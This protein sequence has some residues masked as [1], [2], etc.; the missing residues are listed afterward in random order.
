MGDLR[1][2]VR[3]EQGA[4]ETLMGA[5]PGF[6]GYQDKEDRRDAD[7]LLRM[8]LVGLLND[9]RD[10]LSRFQA[11]LTAEGQ[12]KP[13]T[14]LNR[15]NRRLLRTRD[16]IEHASYGYAGFFDPI[17]VEAA[18][19]D[20]LY[21]FDRSLKEYIANVDAAAAK[22][23]DADTEGRANAIAA[24]GEAMDELDQMVDERNEAVA[25]LAQ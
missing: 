1:D 3:D 16:R 6:R 21:E 8:H 15:I 4:L 11:K 9:A 12:F 22:M 14:D 17:K 13:V 18:A 2:R 5:I 10:H 20:R 24:L 7:K 25:Q 19:L 23:S